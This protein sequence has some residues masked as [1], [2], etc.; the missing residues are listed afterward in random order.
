MTTPAAI[1]AEARAAAALAARTA[2]AALP[3]NAHL[4]LDCGFA[5]VVLHPARGP[6]VA[7]L[8]SQ[9]VGHKHHPSGWCIWYSDL[10]PA[11]LQNVSVHEAAAKAASEVLQR[12][13]FDA[14]WSSRLD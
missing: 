10:Y 7:H 6:F 13:G 3:E 5:W 11:V 8:R 12:H 4:A 14:H 1:W 2:T 9:G